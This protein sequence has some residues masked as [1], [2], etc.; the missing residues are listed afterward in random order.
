M[1][2]LVCDFY[3]LTCISYWTFF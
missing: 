2:K 3:I 1:H